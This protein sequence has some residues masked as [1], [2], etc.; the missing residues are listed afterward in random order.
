M[1]YI[2]ETRG[3]YIPCRL[4]HI[5]HVTITDSQVWLVY[6]SHA[7]KWLTATTQS[8]RLDRELSVRGLEEFQSDIHPR[9]VTSVPTSLE[10]DEIQ[11]SLTD[12][13]E[14]AL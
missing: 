14:I 6:I 13:V 11:T 12:P 3:G 10:L 5:I 1:Y 9:F 2:S 8:E 4:E 7:P